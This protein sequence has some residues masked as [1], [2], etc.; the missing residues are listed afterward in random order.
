MDDCLTRFAWMAL[1]DAQ[2]TILIKQHVTTASLD[3]LF[4]GRQQERVERCSK[5]TFGR[6]DETDKG[7]LASRRYERS[8]A[9]AFLTPIQ[10]SARRFHVSTAID[11]D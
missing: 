4:S 1:D 11:K 8:H 5:P 3:D 10:F 2:Q 7:S 9:T 6:P